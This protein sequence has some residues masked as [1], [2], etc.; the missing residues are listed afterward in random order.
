MVHNQEENSQEKK[1]AESGENNNRI[2][3]IHTF[4][5]DAR[6]IIKS[7]GIDIAK[8]RVEVSDKELSELKKLKEFEKEIKKETGL[9]D[10]EKAKVKEE[11]ERAANTSLVPSL[12]IEKKLEE[13]LKL[14]NSPENKE[15]EEKTDTAPPIDNKILPTNLN[16]KNNFNNIEGP[17]DKFEIQNN[18]SKKIEDIE[19][20]KEV[21]KKKEEDLQ[22]KKLK[23][24]QK[25]EENK[26]FQDRKE[27]DNTKVKKIIYYILGFVLI[28][29]GIFAIYFTFFRSEK[30]IEEMSVVEIVEI[31][32]IKTDNQIE[33]P[34]DLGNVDRTI[35]KAASSFYQLNSLTQIIPTLNNTELNVEQFFSS[36]DINPPVRFIKSVDEKFSIGVYSGNSRETELVMV[37]KV[38]SFSTAFASL[39]EW[40]TFMHDDFSKFI[41][42]SEIQTIQL[43]TVEELIDEEIAFSPFRD[44]IINNIDIRAIENNNDI[45][46]LWYP[47]GRSYIVI[48]SGIESFESIF[49]RLSNI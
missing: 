5:D 16:L 13:D 32:V 49:S 46:F 17:K 24:K 33:V 9:L 21:I 30:T 14:Q 29:V 43:N 36:L 48:S 47:I 27:V 39:L 15:I 7:S 12:S 44:R 22:L 42:L 2:R 35:S 4:Q 3:I 41:N 34:L 28:S 40:E 6:D 25:R 8:Q 11:Y 18:V 19:K 23:L 26:I 1:E 37:F 45:E 10:E 20:K 31:P 38:L